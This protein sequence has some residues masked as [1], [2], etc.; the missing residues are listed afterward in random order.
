MKQLNAQ[1]VDKKLIN[2]P[3]KGLIF[4]TGVFLRA[5]IGALIQK[6]RLEEKWSGRFAVIQ[7]SNRPIAST[8]NKQNGLYTLLTRG[9]SGQ[10]IVD[11]SQII[12]TYSRVIQAQ[13]QWDELL[14]LAQSSEVQYVFSNTTENGLQLHGNDMQTTAVPHSF[15]AKLLALLHHR[16]QHFNGSIHK[17]WIIVPTELLPNNG[18][19]LKSLIIELADALKYP[20][21]FHHWLNES[22]LFVNTLVDRIVP[23][24]PSANEKPDLYQR[25]GYEDPLMVIAEPY[26]FFALEG[27]KDLVDKLACLKID[28]Q[29]IVVDKDISW[30]RERKLRLLNAVHAVIT[31]YFLSLNY[32]SVQQIM[33]NAEA[34]DYV[35][36]LMFKEI[37]P[38][39]DFPTDEAEKYAEEVLERFSNPYLVHNLSDI[40]VNIH[41]K[42]DI[43]VQPIQDK[44]EQKFGFKAERISQAHD[45]LTAIA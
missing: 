40:A 2:Q 35:H 34:R 8:F 25:M 37:I 44:F 28:G 19:L 24:S 11:D 4:G 5:F 39:L 38:A 15:P 27:S 17:G 31:P 16:F 13:K 1:F 3:E 45:C 26:T 41:N 30:Y 10:S 42:W 20:K 33:E 12:S 29:Q 9:I 21:S 18:D 22:C 7:S 23:G 36:A 32:T 6:S 43:R 14:Q